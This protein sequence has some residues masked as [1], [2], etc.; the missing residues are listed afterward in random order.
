MQP[1]IRKGDRDPAGKPG[2][3][4]AWQAIVGV[5]ADGAFGPATEASTKRWQASKGLVADGIVGPVSWSTASGVPVPPRAVGTDAEA[6]AIAKRAAPGMPEEQLQY[7]LTVARGEGYYGKG[8]K[9]DGVGSNNWG[10]VQ[11]TGSAGSFVTTDHHADG[12]AYQGK[13][14]RYS[15]PEEG[16]N[17]MARVLFTGGKRGATGAAEIKS[18]LAKGSLRDAV[19]AQHRNGYFE[20]A[21]EK[22]LTAVSRNYA[23]LTGSGVFRQ[24]LTELGGAAGGM[25]GAGL[26]VVGLLA[27]GGLVAWLRSKGGG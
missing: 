14:K 22:Y 4:A 24:L 16:F 5:Q 27:V 17:D 25:G 13:F 1:T 8:W 26:A 11:G 9:G 3:V 20:L 18:A 6:Y 7:A 23:A 2:P 19:F 10:A 15:T 21:P 12:S